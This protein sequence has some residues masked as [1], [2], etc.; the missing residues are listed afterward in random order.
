M[1]QKFVR[2]CVL[3]KCC[4]FSMFVCVLEGLHQSEGLVH[5]SAHRQVIHSDLSED[6]FTIDDE[7]TSECVSLVLKKDAVVFGDLMCEV[8]KKRNLHWSQ[9][10]LFPWGVDP[11]QMS[12]LRVHRASDHL[13]INGLKLVHTITEGDD[14]SRT[15]KREVQ[16]V[17]EENQV[18]SFVI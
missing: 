15:H 4:T 8:R 9:T 11:G 1:N 2:Q 14:L 18:F 16:R 10:S 3:Y 7:E 6:T 12:K 13:C 17:E 5:R